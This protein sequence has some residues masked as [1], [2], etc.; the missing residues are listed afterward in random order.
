MSW[1]TYTCCTSEPATDSMTLLVPLLAPPTCAL[2]ARTHTHPLTTPQRGSKDP[3]A[4]VTAVSANLL[5]RERR[6]LV[7]EREVYGIGTW[8]RSIYTHRHMHIHTTYSL[9]LIISNKILPFSRAVAEFICSTVWEMTGCSIL[10]TIY[11]S[12]KEPDR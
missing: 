1:R 2:S 10:I 3:V 8:R 7:D 12:D 6:T 4:M 9:Y 5:L 11:M